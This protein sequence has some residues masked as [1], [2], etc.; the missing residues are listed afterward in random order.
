M[1]IDRCGP[2]GHTERC[3]RR[4][5]DERAK[6]A[7]ERRAVHPELV[8]RVLAEDLGPEQMAALRYAADALVGAMREIHSLVVPRWAIVYLA[9]NAL[10][11]QEVLFWEDEI[12]GPK[13]AGESEQLVRSGRRRGRESATR[14][15]ADLRS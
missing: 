12:D 2:R 3:L 15:L 4:H 10:G 5:R 8:E 11:I 6:W 9:A 14:S 7:E 13:T 1:T